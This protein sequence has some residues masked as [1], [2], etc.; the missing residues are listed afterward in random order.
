MDI[1]K[2]LETTLRD[3]RA[4]DPK[5]LMSRMQ[6]Y[7]LLDGCPDCGNM[8]LSYVEV[9]PTNKFWWCDH[10]KIIVEEVE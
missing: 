5:V 7:K 8:D 1:D 4:A 2:W 6:E 10:C 9:S 3:I